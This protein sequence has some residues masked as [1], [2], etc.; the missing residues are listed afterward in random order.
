MEK[1]IEKKFLL[2]FRLMLLC[3]ILIANAILHIINFEY[4]WLIF[5][6]NIMLFTM[7]GDIKERFRSVELGGLVGLVLTVLTLLAVSGA[8]GSDIV[9]VAEREL[10]D[11]GG[12]AC[13]SRYWPQPED[14][15]RSHRPLLSDPAD[16]IRRSSWF[17][18]LQSI[19][20]KPLTTCSDS[21]L[22]KKVLVSPKPSKRLLMKQAAT[23]WTLRRS[24]NREQPT[25]CT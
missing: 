6:S 3:W 16:R 11:Y 20:M 15:C 13:G 5:I 21:R 1:E 25:A 22:M 7:S 14:W 4:S 24:P 23:S 2:Y 9:E 18:R 8:G 10:R 12:T 19:R 17:R